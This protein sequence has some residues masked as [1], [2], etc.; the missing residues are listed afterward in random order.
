MEEAIE[1]CRD[2]GVIAE[3]LAP[4]VDGP[5]RGEQRARAFVAPHNELEEI[6]GGGGGKLPHPEIV[7]D[8]QRDGSELGHTIAPGAVDARLGELIEERMR[9]EVEDAAAL[10]D[11]GLADR[12]RVQRVLACKTVTPTSSPSYRSVTSSSVSSPHIDNAG[13]ALVR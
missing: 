8:Q 2:R 10:V 4:V 12:L 9:L 13:P 11:G 6:L 1:E 7:D 3:E 5:V